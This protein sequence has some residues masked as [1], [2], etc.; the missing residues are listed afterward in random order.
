MIISPNLFRFKIDSARKSR[1][2]PRYPNRKSAFTAQIPI[3]GLKHR[4]S[5]ANRDCERRESEAHGHRISRTCLFSPACGSNY[6]AREIIKEIWGKEYGENFHALRVNIS[7]LRN[8][9]RAHS[10]QYEYIETKLGRGYLIP[11]NEAAE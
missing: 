11:G 9:L 10:G 7:R 1:S 5:P 6:V 8:K 3:Q 4:F 2:S